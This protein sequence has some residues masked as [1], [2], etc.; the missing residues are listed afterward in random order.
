[1]R[2]TAFIPARYKSTRFPGKPLLTIAGKSM[3][4]HVYE[5]ASSCRE[6][7]EVYVATD[8]ERILLEVRNFGGKALMTAREHH[9]GSDRI[10]EAAIKIGLKDDDL[11]VNIQGDQPVFDP[12]SIES[13][14]SPFKEKGEV[15]SMSTL[16]YRIRD[17]E[18]ITNPNIV[19][20]V[21]DKNEWA[22]FFS[23]SPIPYYREADTDPVYYKHL[24][25]YAYHL[26]FL[27]AFSHIRPGNLEVAEKLE[28]LRVLESGYKIKVVETL[29]DSIEIDTPQDREKVE[30]M[31]ARQNTKNT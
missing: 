3:I 5:R 7:G 27:K 16:R 21:T 12:S 22:L 2:I 14:V 23:R 20:V 15:F 24:G 26:S 19:K 10:A 11:I 9:S 13:L 31:I 28:Q 25:F 29:C 4:R 6:I 8:D 1:M 17:R 18:E 30:R